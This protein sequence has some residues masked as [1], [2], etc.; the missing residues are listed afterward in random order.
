MRW[1]H[2]YRQ[3]RPF[4]DSEAWMLFRAAAFAEAFGWTCL[5]IGILYSEHLGQHWPVAVAG[6]I[7]GTLF[8]IYLAAAALLGPSLRW[9]LW[10]SALAV[11][12]SVPPYGSLVYEMVSAFLRK[13]QDAQQFYA[14][15]G[16]AIASQ[17]D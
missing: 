15:T 11:M 14:A 4:S 8:L 3:W 7:H 16:F 9:P 10:R 2:A 12:C 17:Q 6:Q 13:H 5:I 1:L